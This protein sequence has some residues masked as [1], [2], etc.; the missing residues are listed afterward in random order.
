MRMDS[1]TRLDEEVSA[2]PGV[3]VHPHRFGG[4]E[5]KFGKAEI[6]H[7]HG[8]EPWIFRFRKRFATRCWKK[9]SENASMGS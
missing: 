2:W 3:S 7:V 6:G 4:R 5:F 1:L 9:V 8:D